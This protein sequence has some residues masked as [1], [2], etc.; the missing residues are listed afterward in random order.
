MLQVKAAL[1]DTALDA[2]AVMGA[3]A[4]ANRM[5]L[6]TRSMQ[7]AAETL[8]AETHDDFTF[9]GQPYPGPACLQTSDLSDIC[10]AVTARLS[11]AQKQ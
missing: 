2:S 10:D 9:E 4:A 3:V 6:L 7:H 1:A 11:E 5:L 8:S